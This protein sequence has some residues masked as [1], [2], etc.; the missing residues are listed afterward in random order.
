MLS[1]FCP[2]FVFL[3][4][5][6]L[7]YLYFSGDGYKILSAEKACVPPPHAIVK[8]YEVMCERILAVKLF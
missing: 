3:L 8:F 1:R 7:V 4:T 2:I 5:L 6:L